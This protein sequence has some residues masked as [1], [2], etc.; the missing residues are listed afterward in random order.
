[1][2]YKGMLVLRVVGRLDEIEHAAAGN[3]RTGEGNSPGRVANTRSNIFYLK[4]IGSIGISVASLQ[5]P[6]FDMRNIHRE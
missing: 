6:V 5:L 4:G 3:E 1:M 2:L